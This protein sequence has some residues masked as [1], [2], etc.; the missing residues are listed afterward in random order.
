MWSTRPSTSSRQIKTNTIS[1]RATWSST[2]KL[3]RTT[4]LFSPLLAQ[5]KAFDSA[6][7]G[8]SDKRSW[9]PCQLRCRWCSLQR[10]MSRSTSSRKHPICSKRSV[11]RATHIRRG[12]A[13]R[14]LASVLPLI[15]L[16][17]SRGNRLLPSMIRMCAWKINSSLSICKPMRTAKD[18]NQAS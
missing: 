2:L 8:E 16:L 5:S 7:K 1:T 11:K 6:K 12:L 15:S 18:L 13:L 3:P 14:G 10:L 9:R 4:V 17:W